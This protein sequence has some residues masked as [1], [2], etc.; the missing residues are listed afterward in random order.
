[1][2]AVDYSVVESS[3]VMRLLI[4]FYLFL[5]ILKFCLYCLQLKIYA[6]KSESL[7]ILLSEKVDGTSFSSLMINFEK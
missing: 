5:G 7:P 2:T 6:R 4:C 1:M 3:L